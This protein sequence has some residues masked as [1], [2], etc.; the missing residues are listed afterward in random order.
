MPTSSKLV[1]KT[2]NWIISPI[3]WPPIKKLLLQ[4]VSNFSKRIQNWFWKQEIELSKQKMELF[5][6]LPD[7]QS[8]NFFYKKFL[9]FVNKFKAGFENR[10]WKYFSYFLGVNLKTFLQNVSNFTNESKT[11]FVSIIIQTRY[12]FLKSYKKAHNSLVHTIILN[13]WE[14]NIRLKDF[15]LVD[16][17]PIS[18][19]LNKEN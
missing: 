12:Y 6:L 9:N 19:C 7:L 1:L 10:K 3:S 8:K 18:I 2:G 17:F 16:V 4:K 14:A 15:K 13:L 11:G 5:L